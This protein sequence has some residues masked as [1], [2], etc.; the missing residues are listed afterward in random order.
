MQKGL[1]G[2]KM[3]IELEIL[4]ELKKIADSFSSEL[5]NKIKKVKK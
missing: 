4:V 1:R 2:Y 3:N 5:K